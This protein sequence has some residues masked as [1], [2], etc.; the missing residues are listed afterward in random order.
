MYRGLSGHRAGMVALMFAL[1][2]TVFA[3][4][5]VGQ[6]GQDARALEIATK[7]KAKGV[8]LKEKEAKTATIKGKKFTLIPADLSGVKTRE[9]L[10]SGVFLGELD[11]EAST[12]EGVSLPPGK[13]E[14]YAVLVQ[15]KWE[16]YAIVKGGKA[17]KPAKSVEE[18]PTPPPNKEPTFNEGSGCWWL[19]LIITGLNVCW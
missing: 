12:A 17:V 8:K 13:Y 9:D 11:T 14:L 4:P 19:W 6:G 3:A 2:T 7:V 1:V 18:R 5:A 16:A 15:D 10:K